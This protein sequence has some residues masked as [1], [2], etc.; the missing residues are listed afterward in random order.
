MNPV[1]ETIKEESRKIVKMKQKE[2]SAKM[3]VVPTDV[4]TLH[5]VMYVPHYLEKDMFVGPGS[6]RRSKSNLLSQG[7]STHSLMLWERLARV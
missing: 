6:V 4:Y 2:E 1:Q 3:P 7:A 5:G